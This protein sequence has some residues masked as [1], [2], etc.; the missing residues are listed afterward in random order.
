MLGA[1][2]VV[3]IQPN[4]LPKAFRCGPNLVALTNSYYNTLSVAI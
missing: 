4:S 1:T 3:G 2:V